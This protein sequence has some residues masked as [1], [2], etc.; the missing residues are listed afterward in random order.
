MGNFLKLVITLENT[1][2]MSL[3]SQFNWRRLSDLAVRAMFNWRLEGFVSILL[4]L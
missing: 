4:F 2:F 3:Q 1:L